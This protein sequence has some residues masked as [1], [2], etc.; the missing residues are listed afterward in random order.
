MRLKTAI[1]SA[2]LTSL[3]CIFPGIVTDNIITAVLT[4][5]IA[6]F[7]SGMFLYSYQD[8]INDSPIDG[9]A[10]I[11][12]NLVGC[13]IAPIFVSIGYWQAFWLTGTTVVLALVTGAFFIFLSVRLISTSNKEAFELMDK[14]FQARIKN[15]E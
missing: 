10:I 15:E 11:A 1:L 4:G 8:P 6:S 3:I 14:W 7:L 13:F 12:A 9:K 2:L 5:S